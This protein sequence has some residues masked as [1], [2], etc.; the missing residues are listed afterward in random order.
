[1]LK[2]RMM[3]LISMILAAA[4]VRLMP[5]PPNMAPIA[6]IAL[7]GGAF[8]SQKWLAF[9]IPLTALFISD[10]A[11]GGFYLGMDVVYFS[12]AL[13]VCIGLWL[14]KHR[15]VLP[16]AGAALASSILFFVVTNF[17]EWAFSGMYPADFEGLIACYTAALPFFTNTVM[18]DLFYTALLFGGFAL[19]ESRFSILR[20]PA[21]RR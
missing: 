18:G 17:G 12:F 21:G 3:V 15:T 20:E 5:H 9:L 10:M 11:L 8:F 2:P 7:F 14:Q 4:L 13:I 19:L 6:A 1:M 16:I